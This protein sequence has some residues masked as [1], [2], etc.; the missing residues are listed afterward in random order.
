MSSKLFTPFMGS[1]KSMR[2]KTQMAKKNNSVFG[3]L[4]FFGK[5]YMY[6]LTK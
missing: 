3:Y 4:P 5:N 6:C 2:K 1:I